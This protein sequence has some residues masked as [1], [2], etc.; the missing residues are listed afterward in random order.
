MP[1]AAPAATT[2]PVNVDERPDDRGPQGADRRL[3]LLG[4]GTARR[5][6]RPP[7]HYGKLAG[8]AQ[9]R[10]NP[11]RPSDY[12]ATGS[13]PRAAAC[14]GTAA[15]MERLKSAIAGFIAFP[16]NERCKKR[17]GK[18]F[19]HAIMT[20]RLTPRCEADHER[21]VIFTRGRSD[22]C[23]RSRASV[24][25]AVRSISRPTTRRAISAS[26]PSLSRRCAT[27]GALASLN[28]ECV[29]GGG[30]TTILRWTFP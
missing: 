23:A 27:D 18:D 7:R 5:R 21:P 22:S 10:G 1:N 25:V 12:N 16:G 29:N 13:A 30:G 15:S 8:Y 24:C 3:D 20:G 2:R 9:R 26:S 11:R 19:A 6:R 14:C 4:A 17:R 28:R